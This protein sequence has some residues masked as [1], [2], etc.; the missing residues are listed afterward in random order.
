MQTALGRLKLRLAVDCATARRYDFA[1]RLHVES[2]TLTRACVSPYLGSEIP[3]AE[4]FGLDP[5]R[6]YQLVRD[7]NELEKAASSFCA[8][9]ILLGH[10]PV[11]ANDPRPEIVAG[12]TG[13]SARFVDP[14]IF[15][16][17]V[18]WR[19][20]AIQA[21]EDGSAKDLSAGY[22]Y[23]LAW[24]P[25]SYQG[26]AYDGRMTQIQGSHVALVEKGRVPGAMVLDRSLRRYV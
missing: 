15:N 18:V 13:T 4:A 7:P 10:A 12:A 16:S 5:N 24:G 3:D 20:D 19:A 9:P 8:L 6:T 14:Y 2:T 23:K 22:R 26:E 25:S 21:I 17:I 11:H 1:G